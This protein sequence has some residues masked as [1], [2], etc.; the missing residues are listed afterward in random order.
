MLALARTF[1][2]GKIQQ[3]RQSAYLTL[4]TAIL[5]E[6]DLFPG[7]RPVA[8]T[9]HRCRVRGDGE[10]TREP[11]SIQERFGSPQCA[12]LETGDT[13]MAQPCCAESD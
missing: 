1:A 13:A 5:A 7:A 3:R 6:S 10:Q 8:R 2:A 4:A 9:R 11:P 12:L